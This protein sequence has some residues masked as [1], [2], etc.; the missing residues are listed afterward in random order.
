ME[1]SVYF[2]I[3]LMDF[4]QYSP[5]CWL[6]NRTVYNLNPDLVKQN[7]V[8]ALTDWFLCILNVTIN[9]ENFPNQ[10][11][12]ILKSFYLLTLLHSQQF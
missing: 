9:K 2:N 5:T 6:L 1:S 11:Q 10:A 8:G 7:K 12:V 3:K 4:V